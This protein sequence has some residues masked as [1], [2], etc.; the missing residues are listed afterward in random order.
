MALFSPSTKNPIL[1]A[2]VPRPALAFPSTAPDC[3]TLAVAATLARTA[4]VTTPSRRIK[5]VRSL[6]TNAVAKLN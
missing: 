5:S 4:V 6:S 3:A 1:D 2:G